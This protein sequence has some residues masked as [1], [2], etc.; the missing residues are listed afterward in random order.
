MARQMAGTC[1]GVVVAGPQWE[2]GTRK[3]VPE[4]ID[5]LSRG[6]GVQKKDGCRTRQRPRSRRPRVCVS[7]HRL[8]DIVLA[9]PPQRVLVDLN[10]HL[11][12][13]RLRRMR[14]RP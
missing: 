6:Q 3:C 1:T 7:A 2:D 9:V 13:H 11:G 4:A 5:K 12:H 14:C 8:P 10:V